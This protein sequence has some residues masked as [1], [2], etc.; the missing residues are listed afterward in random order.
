MIYCDLYIH[1]RRI[2]GRKWRFIMCR[3]HEIR[4]VAPCPST[5][6]AIGQGIQLAH[7]G[8]GSRK[9]VR[10]ALRETRLIAWEMGLRSDRPN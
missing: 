3:T 2:N 1:S 8:R 4:S 10:E 7:Q 6:E 5:G 9:A